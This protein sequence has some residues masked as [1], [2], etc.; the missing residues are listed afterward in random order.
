M[1]ID[2]VFKIECDLTPG[3]IFRLFAKSEESEGVMTGTFREI[4]INE[5]LVYS[6]NWEGSPE[7][8]TV[9]VEFITENQGT[10]VVISQVGFQSMESHELHDQGWVRYFNGLELKILNQ[11]SNH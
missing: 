5:K 11:N 6:W 4:V 10:Q 3:G 7:T 1:A 9:T 8:T 2:P